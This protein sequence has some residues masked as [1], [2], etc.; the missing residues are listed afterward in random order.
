[1]LAVRRWG[2][3]G[4]DGLVAGKEDVIMRDRLEAPLGLSS[5]HDSVHVQQDLTRRWNETH[6]QESNYRSDHLER[7]IPALVC[8][9]ALL[10]WFAWWLVRGSAYG[11]WLCLRPQLS[12]PLRGWATIGRGLRQVAGVRTRISATLPTKTPS[13]SPLALQNQQKSHK[14]GLDRSVA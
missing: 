8:G 3:G 2:V 4:G 6:Q 1:L 10:F 9:I 11:I 14:S 12:V 13:Q 7:E 5:P